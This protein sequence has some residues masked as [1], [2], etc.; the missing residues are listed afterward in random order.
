MFSGSV[1]SHALE[2]YR[3]II[4]VQL[5]SSRREENELKFKTSIE[6]WENLDENVL[7][8][9]CHKVAEQ[10][11]TEAGNILRELR[12]GNPHGQFGRKQ[13]IQTATRRMGKEQ[14]VS[15]CC[16]KEK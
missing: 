11:R 15:D 5:N 13:L 9:K 8:R 4:S 2:A 6:N 12:D 14:Q 7:K 3:M 10:M 1:Q 16:N